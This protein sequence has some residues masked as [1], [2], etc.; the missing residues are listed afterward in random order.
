MD[1]NRT[2]EKVLSRL[3]LPE[4]RTSEP[5]TVVVGGGERQAARFFDSLREFF[6]LVY[7]AASALQELDPDGIAALCGELARLGT[8]A[9][10]AVEDIHHSKLARLAGGGRPI[11]LVW[12]ADLN[13]GLPSRAGADRMEWLNSVLGTG[14]FYLVDSSQDFYPQIFS[15]PFLPG[16][17][18]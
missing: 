9:Y 15:L 11:Y 16:R 4:T 6:P 12:V 14:R 17:R 13:G 18:R 10:L 3:A 2:T 8:C 7:V 1:E 5:I